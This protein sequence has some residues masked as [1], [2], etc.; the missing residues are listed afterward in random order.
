ML[1]CAAYT[2]DNQAEAEEGGLPLYGRRDNRFAK[3]LRCD[4]HGGL[5]CGGDGGEGDVCT[6]KHLRNQAEL[7][8]LIEADGEEGFRKGQEEINILHSMM[9]EKSQKNTINTDILAFILI[10]KCQRQMFI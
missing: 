9:Y 10:L 6:R 5:L 1:S 3:E 7:S 2:E 8:G 4:R